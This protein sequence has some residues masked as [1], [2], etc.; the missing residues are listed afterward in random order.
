[1]HPT[2]LNTN[3]NWNPQTNNSELLKHW[4]EA[5]ICIQIPNLSQPPTISFPSG[6]AS[7]E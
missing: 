2:G 3:K 1:M 5:S 6:A 4:C 7:V